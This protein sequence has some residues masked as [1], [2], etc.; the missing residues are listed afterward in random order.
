MKGFN[1]KKI[2]LTNN[3]NFLPLVMSISPLLVNNNC[4]EKHK[5]IYK[6]I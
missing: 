3:V 1:Y 5:L 6:I 4:R 2:S